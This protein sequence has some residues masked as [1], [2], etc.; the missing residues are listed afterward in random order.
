MR[1]SLCVKNGGYKY[2]IEWTLIQKYRYFNAYKCWL[3][4]ER[5]RRA[6]RALDYFGVSFADDKFDSRLGNGGVS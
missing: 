6:F 3:T 5:A 2:E 1:S 4:R